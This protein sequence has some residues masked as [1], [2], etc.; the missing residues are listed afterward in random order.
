MA[1][2]SISIILKPPRSK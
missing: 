1:L 2:I